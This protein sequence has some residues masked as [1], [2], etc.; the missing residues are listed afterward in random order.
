VSQ[1]VAAR[2][3][4]ACRRQATVRPGFSRMTRPASLSTSR[5]FIT[6]GSDILKGLAS[7]DTE[8]V[9]RALN[10]ARSARRVGSARAAKVRSSVAVE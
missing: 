1:S 9:S 6:A 5:C 2:I 4:S 3:G 10:C 8:I 7:S